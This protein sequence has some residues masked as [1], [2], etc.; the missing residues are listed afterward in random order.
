MSHLDR[1]RLENDQ[2]AGALCDAAFIRAMINT[3]FGNADKA[4]YLSS[5]MPFTAAPAPNARPFAVPAG[6]A[7]ALK[8]QFP[9]ESVVIGVIDDG[10]AIAHPRL[11]LA[12]NETRLL[13]YWDQEA[14]FTEAN[15]TVPFGQE[16]LKVDFGGFDGLDTI[17]ADYCGPYA[18]IYGDRS[19]SA[20]YPKMRN[21]MPRNTSH[22]TAV[23]DLVAGA[24]MGEGAD[25]PVVAVKLPRSS[26]LDTS[27]AHLDFFLLQGIHHILSRADMLTGSDNPRVVIVISYGY[28]GGP[29]D[30]SSLF[31]R[32]VDD[33]LEMAG[34]KDR[35]QIVI[36]SGNGRM[37]RAHAIRPHP[38]P[39]GHVRTVKW[40]SPAGDRTPSVMEVW[41]DII[42]GDPSVPSL[43]F[44]IDPPEGSG[45]GTIDFTDADTQEKLVLHRQDA[46][47]RPVMGDSSGIMAEVVC[48]HPPL[49]PGRR[50]F[51]IWLS[52]TTLPPPDI[53]A[54]PA[55]SP[56]GVWNLR[57][58]TLAPT[59]TAISIWIRRDDSLPGFPMLGRQ[60]SVERD[61]PQE[62]PIPLNQKQWDRWDDFGSASVT[63]TINTLATGQ[64]PVV[65]SGFGAFDQRAA[66]SAAGGPLSPMATGAPAKPAHPKD[67]PAGPDCLAPSQVSHL[68]GIKAANFFGGA[69]VAVS[70]TSFAAPLAAHWIASLYLQGKASVDGKARVR[71]AA[72]VSD[73]T[74]AAAW[75]PRIARGENRF[76]DEVMLQRTFRYDDID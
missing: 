10:F 36:P 35:V 9:G 31:E 56:S 67:R 70:G 19:L 66:R 53:S 37:K 60:S 16:L 23:L 30:G 52:P 46:L 55:L 25:Q 20:Y 12:K 33:I 68:R 39:E 41:T 29:L 63:G 27:G 71:V 8:G 38:G 28:F 7:D 40:R 72:A 15:S 1:V 24:D 13:S 47:G 64:H 54:P 76:F 43:K 14:V 75:K 69:K 3:A 45:S 34:R 5:A 49:H 44:S 4:M 65:T 17:L 26:V 32:A 62:G 48:D 6:L 59:A 73:A 50:R 2:A 21:L 74:M 42:T 11:R 22:G 57:L 18:E 51:M 58:E 61:P